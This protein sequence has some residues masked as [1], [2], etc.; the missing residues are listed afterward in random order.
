MQVSKRPMLVVK[1]AASLVGKRP[2]AIVSE[3]LKQDLYDLA[4]FEEDTD[5][6]SSLSFIMGIFSKENS[7]F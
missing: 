2:D 4:Y 3:P 6:A 1:L 7:R 5:R